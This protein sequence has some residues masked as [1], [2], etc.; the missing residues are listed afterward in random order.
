MTINNSNQT[1]PWRAYGIS[2]ID[3]DQLTGALLVLQTQIGKT[4]AELPLHQHQN[5][6]LILV[7]QGVVTCNVENGYWLVPPNSAMWIPAEHIHSNHSSANAKVSYV[8]IDRRRTD[9]LPITAQLL[10][11][12]AWIQ[13]I[14][15]QLAHE[16]YP[17]EDNA[18]TCAM[19][20]VL[21]LGLEQV[22][23]LD[24]YAPLPTEPR[25]QQMAQSILQHPQQRVRLSTWAQRFACSERTLARHIQ[26]QTGMNFRRW[27]QQLLVLLAL[28]KL[29]E[30]HAVKRIASDLGYESPSAL[31]ALFKQIVGVTPGQLQL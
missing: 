27:R 28:Q 8:F 1:N 3:P 21:I 2:P 15:Q 7:H 25:L 17:Y 12:P 9:R 31:I 16:P 26:K 4:A 18:L 6:Q 11:T 13:A 10:A 19:Q 23:T 24:L 20:E 22:K 14:I 29:G 30:G 5:G